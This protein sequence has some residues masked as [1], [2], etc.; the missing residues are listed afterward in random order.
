MIR[1]EPENKPFPFPLHGPERP[2]SNAEFLREVFRDLPTGA[3]TWVTT[4]AGDPSVVGPEGWKGFAFDPSHKV[5]EIV[6]GKNSFFCISSFTGRPDPNRP[7]V[8]FGVSRRKALHTATHAFVLDDIGHGPGAKV[9]VARLPAHL[10]PSWVLETSAGNFQVGYV[11]ETPVEDGDLAARFLDALVA[12]GL[13]VEKDPGMKGVT[14]YVRL[15]AGLN[16]KEKYKIDGEGEGWD[17]RL[18]HWKPSTRYQLEDLCGGFGLDLTEIR[19]GTSVLGRRA[20][21]SSVTYLNDPWVPILEQA[22][23]RMERP[24]DKGPDGIWIDVCCP[25]VHE[26]SGQ[27]DNGSAYCVGGGYKCNHGHCESRDWGSVRGWLL[28]HPDTAVRQAA[29][30]LAGELD[31]GLAPILMPEAPPLDTIPAGMIAEEKVAVPSQD[32]IADAFVA[33]RGGADGLLHIGQWNKWFL[34][35]GGVWNE[36]VT[37]SI[38]A[39]LRE[40][41]RAEAGGSKKAAKAMGNANFIGGAEKLAR[42]DQRI[43]KPHTVLDADP[44]VLNVRNGIADLRTGVVG[45]HDPQRYQSKICDYAPGG[46]CP[47]WH[48]FLGEITKSD[49]DLQRY[50]QR[51]IG[52]ALI[53]KVIEHVLFFAYGTGRNGKGVFFN[54]VSRILGPFVKIATMDTFTEQHGSRHLTELAM[55][56]GARLVMAEETDQGARWNESRI[57]ILTGGNPITANFMRQD[58]FT[59]TPQFALFIA[60]N[61][62]PRLR[63]VDEAI[64]GRMQLIP[65]DA[66]FPPEKQDK[67]LEERLVTTEAGGILQWMLDGCR[68]YQA[69]GLS[70][71]KAVTD[72]TDAYLNNQDLFGQWLTDKCEVDPVG[73]K[74]FLTPIK[75]LWQSWKT[76]CDAAEVRPG[77]QSELTD[78]LG[79][80][81]CPFVRLANGRG[82]K[83]VKLKEISV[84]F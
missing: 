27:E 78:Q 73:E 26:H 5:A 22:V 35:D 16:G 46:A 75:D 9:P 83:N 82:H 51:A 66:Y 12:D 18:V 25:W 43:S 60:G 14:R 31:F 69:E 58:L 72:A 64:R 30:D 81:K 6:G 53:G 47:G 13:Q 33:S 84:E 42:S 38:Y 71:P 62:K 45:P 76:F 3:V 1:A 48:K 32:D 56:R 74:K 50:L 52:Y 55:L 49:E 21:R 77:R 44:W 39:G 29:N 40:F 36:D 15:P 37:T 65:F 68:D 23:D 4:F 11:M 59:F 19:S 20:G 80:R 57:K 8:R 61:H 70:P 28:H 24:N 34:F 41:A 54:V 63:N 67:G 7:G 17:H 2:V 79:A 10:D